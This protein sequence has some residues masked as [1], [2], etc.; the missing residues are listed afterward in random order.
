M[1]AILESAK[2]IKPNPNW[3]QLP[4]FDR[5]GWETLPFGAF[6]DCIS[7]RAHPT[8]FADAIY[9]GLEHLDPENL[10]IRRWG[11]GSDVEGV[12]LRFYKGD[13]IFGRRR[14]YQRKLAVAEVD[15][16]CSAHAMV[17]RAN[18]ELCLP[19][20]L[21]FLMM[22]DAFMKRAVEISVGS[23]SPT[24][25]W[26]VLKQ[27]R[28]ALPPLDLQRRIAELLWAVDD[29]DQSVGQLSY[30][31]LR[32]RDTYLRSLYDEGRSATQAAAA[33]N[34]PTWRLVRL[35]EIV[36]F[37]DGKRVP[38]KEADRA[39]RRGQY[40]YYG[41]SGVI[42]S[43]DDYLFDEPL[44]LLGED[45]ANIV[46]RSTPLAFR[47]SGKIWV[48]NHAHVMRVLPPN[49]LIY[50]EYYLESLDYKPMVSG[51][52]QPK[53][54]KGVCERIDVPL[55]TAEIQARV[56]SK[57]RDYE[58]ALGALAAQRR[59]NRELTRAVLDNITR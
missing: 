41:A 47:V 3:A 49:S 59:A 15:G 28:F 48:N 36:E 6:A 24:I 31:S 46:D 16:I 29:Y 32:A 43:I 4:L 55:P 20:F 14:A 45:G 26:G 9:V 1:K 57:L 40:P 37:L 51:T 52:A 56:E 18:P 19:E 22:S 54:T 53:L 34:S 50:L 5:S 35:D 8:G 13:I 33:N 10:H 11:K 17:V 21:P 38:I 27:Q 30:D 44:L 42:D 25:S 2:K 7:E 23:L 12:K 39:K 58:E